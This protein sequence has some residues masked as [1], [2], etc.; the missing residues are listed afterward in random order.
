MRP[1]FHDVGGLWDRNGS[2]RDIYVQ[3]METVH[4]ERF[5]RM[6]AECECRYT[7]D[8]VPLPFPGTR[9][10][11]ANRDGS[12]LLSILLGGPVVNCHFFVAQQLELDVCPKEVAGPA[13]HDKVLAFVEKLAHTVGLPADI[14][15]E[16]GEYKPFLTYSPETNSWFQH[17]DRH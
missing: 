2:L 7:F 14:T 15:P 3:N 17:A 4:W 5:E 11:L 12:H 16:N 10:V 6:I 1:N 8:G 13:E 9:S